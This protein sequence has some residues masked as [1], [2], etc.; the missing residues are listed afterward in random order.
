[1]PKHPDDEHPDRG[2]AACITWMLAALVVAASIALSLLI[3]EF[4]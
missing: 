1:M 2:G 4:C 3:S